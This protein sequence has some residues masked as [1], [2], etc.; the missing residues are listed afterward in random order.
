MLIAFQCSAV[1]I[2]KIKYRGEHLL[3]EIPRALHESFDPYIITF[4]L[5]T[6]TVERLLDCLLF[7][8][9]L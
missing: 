7:H 9:H 8:F 1:Y 3:R 6:G 5:E 4:D 2:Y